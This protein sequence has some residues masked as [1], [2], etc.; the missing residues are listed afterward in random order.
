MR[1]RIEALSHRTLV[2][3]LALTGVVT[4]V[5][6]NGRV[7]LTHP[8]EVFYAQTAREMLE[9]HTWTT[10]YLFDAPQ[11]EK[12]IFFYWLMMTAF[13]LA[14]V[15]AFTARLAPALFGLFL[16]AGLTY[17]LAWLLLRRKGVAFLSGGVLLTSWMHIALSRAVLTDMVFTTWVV[18]GW[19][20]FYWGYVN[21]RR[22][23]VGIVLTST[24]ASLAVLTKGL[25]GICFIFGGIGLFLVVRRDKNF[26]RR[27]EVRRA[28]LLAGVI[29][30]VLVVP[31]HALMIHRYGRAFVG[32]YVLNVHWHRVTTAEHRNNDTWF[33]YPLVLFA[34]MAPWLWAWPSAVAAAFRGL[35]RGKEEGRAVA[36]LGSCAAAVFVFT[37]PAHSKLATYI[38]PAFPPVAI[39]FARAL[40][41]MIGRRV[42]GKVATAGG[43]QGVGVLI[44]LAY[45]LHQA[46]AYRSYIGDMTLVGLGAAAFGFCSAVLIV[47]SLRRRPLGMILSSAFLT[48]VLMGGVYGAGPKADP[49]VSCRTI[50]RDIMDADPQGETAILAGK[51]YVR[52]IRYYT[53]RGTAVLDINGKGFF[54]PHPIPYL[55][56][57]AGALRFLRAHPRTL[58]VLR[59]RGLDDVRRITHGAGFAV[60]VLA[61]EGDKVL[62]EVLRD[63][64]G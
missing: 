17:L 47:S 51:F 14:G 36:F 18:A 40:E 37:V 24:A 63:P 28:A 27:S 41:G 4:L 3:I 1:D 16:G 32:E 43:L 6:G 64:S 57:D 23:S 9:R 30:A 49:W 8:D 45:G 35:R 15:S 33:F 13:R 44:G 12:P 21:P 26:L 53:Q 59:R 25:L 56:T 38:L 48:F 5:W 58:V 50:G 11:F 54:S 2:A 34:G 20:A 10:P 52:G 39:L 46:E 55:K 31:W 42:S 7:S 62:A 61:E 29:F 60:H 19:T 22:T